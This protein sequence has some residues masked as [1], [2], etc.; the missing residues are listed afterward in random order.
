MSGP[1]VQ[2]QVRLGS[3]RL[4]GK[5]LYHLGSRRVLEWVV[6]RC[7]RA[8]DP[9]GV[10]VAVGDEPEND[11]ITEWCDR[12][13]VRQVVGPEDDLLARHLAAAEA[14]D[15]DPVV[16]VTG[17]CPFVP[18]GEIDRLVGEHAASDARYTTNVTDEMP[19]G[20]AVDVIDRDVLAELR[21]LEEFHPVMRLRENPEA[22]SVDFSPDERWTAH[23]E[24]HVAVDT[25]ADYWLLTD[26]LAA[27]GEDPFDVVRWVSQ[28]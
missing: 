14:T 21:A 13:D 5:V 3:T 27:V 4:P 28:R 12:N 19:I 6:D 10:V 17:D 24:A 2:I 1:T 18:P 26:A 25:P 7:E 15:G 23:S 8:R 11:A 20:T 16:R 22:W 9:E